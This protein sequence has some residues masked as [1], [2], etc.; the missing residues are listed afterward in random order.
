MDVLESKAPRQAS[1]TDGNSSSL[2]LESCD[3][4]RHSQMRGSTGSVM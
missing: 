1:D 3:Y 4:S 2:S